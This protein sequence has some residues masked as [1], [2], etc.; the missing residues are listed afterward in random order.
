MSA[1]SALASV[2]MM[3][4]SSAH[5]PYVFVFLLATTVTFAA[6]AATT[7][8]DPY[9]SVSMVVVLTRKV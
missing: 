4:Y 1:T 2:V 5:A 7:L 3:D 6:R 9:P 8:A